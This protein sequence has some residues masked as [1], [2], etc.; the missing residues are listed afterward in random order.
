MKLGFLW[1]VEVHSVVPRPKKCESPNIGG[2]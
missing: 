1:P 2:M